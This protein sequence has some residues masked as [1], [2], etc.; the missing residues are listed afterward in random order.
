MP[1]PTDESVPDNVPK[2]KRPQWRETWNRV[3]K[4]TGDEEKAFKA[5]NAIL[6]ESSTDFKETLSI[7]LLES[8]DKTGKVWDVILIEEGFSKN[9]KRG[10]DGKFHQRYYPKESIVQIVELLKEKINNTGI[11]AFT[12]GVRPTDLDHLPSEAKAEKPYALVDNQ[13]GWF[14]EPRLIETVKDGI[15][16]TAAAAKFIFD[17][18]ASRL[19]GAIKDA[20]DRGQRRYAQFSIDALGSSTLGAVEGRL[21]EIVDTV[22][23]TDSIDIVSE[24]AAGGRF[25]RLVASAGLTTKEEEVNKLKELLIKLVEAVQPDLLKDKD[26]AKLE[27]QEVFGIFEEAMKKLSES[28]EPTLADKMLSAQ[29]TQAYDLI[30]GEKFYDAQRIF[31]SVLGIEPTGGGEPA[32]KPVQAPVT[33]IVVQPPAAGTPQPDPA[34]ATAITESQKRLDGIEKSI[35]LQESRV[36]LKSELEDSKLPPLTLK[37][38]QL[39]FQDRTFESKELKE[40]I[41]QERKYLAELSGTGNV[42]VPGQAIELRESEKDKLGLGVLGFFLGEDQKDSSGATIPRFKSFKK[43]YSEATGSPLDTSARTILSESCQY[44]PSELRNENPRLARMIE[45]M[46][47]SSWGEILGDNLHKALIKEFTMPDLQGWRQVVSTYAPVSS[48]ETQHRMVMGGYGA[49]PVVA[50]Q[51]TYQSLTSP[52]DAENTYSLEKKGGLEDLTE[53]MVAADKVGAIRMIPKRMALSAAMTLNQEVFDILSDNTATCHDGNILFDNSIHT[54]L[55]TTALSSA[56]LSVVRAAMRSKTPYN[57]TSLPLGAANLPVLILVPN[58]LEALAQ[59]LCTSDYY[60]GVA[61][62]VTT[63]AHAEASTSPNP[64]KGMRYHV[65]DHWTDADNWFACADPKRV[66]MLEMGFYNGN[67]EP[68]LWVQ[69]MP[70]VGSVFNADKI[71]YK[72]RFV[73]GIMIE[74]WVGFYRESV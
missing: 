30:K 17:E 18:G 14:E 1:F 7:Q 12:Y 9:G 39:Q 4:E 8:E 27:G 44:I 36:L 38:I 57:I 16:T 73:Y 69:D 50:E 24:G 42:S 34:V 37:K 65:V 66:P 19:R 67:E 62:Y 22:R 72:I 21:A 43:A 47:T 58:E 11:K 26:H 48:F 49:L 71:T 60:I 53:E 41:D 59:R 68:E 5:A 45:S 54:N 6:K 15:T 2:E 29:L 32:K 20:W 23:V 46:T 10:P 64:H 52:T 61:A 51:G 55:G 33:P 70:N 25:E 13:V 40:S 56:E 3:F 63:E 74:E 31:E 28:T 35:K